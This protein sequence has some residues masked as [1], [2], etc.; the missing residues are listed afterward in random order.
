MKRDRFEHT[1]VID[2]KDIGAHEREDEKHF[3]RPP[4]NARA[5]NQY[6]NDLLVALGGESCLQ[7]GCGVPP[8]CEFAQVANL[9]PRK[10]NGAKAIVIEGKDGRWGW[11]GCLIEESGPDRIGGLH[12][13]L[14]TNNRA[15]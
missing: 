3:C 4:A 1:Q 15:R 10:S 14:L 6:S 2:W 8:N 9:L 5:L 7:I 13:N 12:R 11:A